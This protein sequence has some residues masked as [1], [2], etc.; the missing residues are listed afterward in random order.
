MWLP[1]GMRIGR[2]AGSFRLALLGLGGAALLLTTSAGPGA[3]APNTFGWIYLRGGEAPRP[4]EPVVE[5]LAV[6]D[7]MTGRG[8]EDVP[9]IFTNV[10]G[11][12][13]GADLAIGNLE[14]AL[15]PTRVP[16]DSMFLL[17]P[18]RTPAMLADAGFDLIGIANNHALDAGIAGRAET[19][20]RL[21][22]AGL[23]P[24]EGFAA[25]VREIDGFR[26]AVLAWNDLGAPDPEPLLAAVAQARAEAGVII[27]MVHWGREYQRHPSLPQR[28]LAS[29]LLDAG[30]DVVVGSHPH[31]VQDVRVVEPVQASDRTRLIA[32]SLGNF[33]FDQGWGDTGQ[34]LALRLLFDAGGLRAAQALPLSTAPRPRWM[35]P[36]A[37]AELLARIVPPERVGF[38]CLEDTCEPVEVPAL[39]RSGILGSGAIDL[40]GDGDPEI[41]F[42]L[43]CFFSFSFFFFFFFLFFFFLL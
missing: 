16:D 12:L 18:L 37:S 32:Y 34:G 6:G 11:D 33:V 15:S 29:G 24:V 42:V 22:E 26:L 40:T 31:V 5:V 35:D 19:R 4:N 2:A 38:F 25:V 27:V 8:M 7:V 41:V 39:T 1:D 23:E 10:A 28:D 20:R 30:V 17:L 21:R 43:F 14:G 13:H 3:A 9:G 36:E